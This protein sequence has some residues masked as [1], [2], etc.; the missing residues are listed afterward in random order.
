[1]VNAD[2]AQGIL[3][4]RGRQLDWHCRFVEGCGNGVH[5]NGIMRIRTSGSKERSAIINRRYCSMEENDLRVSADITDDSETS[6]G[7][8]K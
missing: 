4:A 7:G 1:M 8:R 5:R 6:L 2:Y 3:S